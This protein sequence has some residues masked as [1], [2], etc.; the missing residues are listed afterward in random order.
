MDDLQTR[1]KAPAADGGP[2]RR[3]ARQGRAGALQR[4]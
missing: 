2:A 1:E 4:L 3:G